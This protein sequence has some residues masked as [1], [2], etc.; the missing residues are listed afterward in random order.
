MDGIEYAGYPEGLGILAKLEELKREQM[1]TERTQAELMK[2]LEDT[3][4]Q[5]QTANSELAELR[6]Q[7]GRTS[8]T[9]KNP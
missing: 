6:S 8:H 4:G 7:A 2:N 1:E 9:E 3:I 5:V